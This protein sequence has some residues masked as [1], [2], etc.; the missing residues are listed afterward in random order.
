MALGSPRVIGFVP[1][2]PGEGIEVY[3]IGD[4]V[5]YRF[6]DEAQ[7]RVARVYSQ[8]RGAYF[9]TPVGRIR[10]DEVLRV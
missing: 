5:T 1:I 8:P 9:R 4:R 10:L 3:G 6:S 2:I 7:V